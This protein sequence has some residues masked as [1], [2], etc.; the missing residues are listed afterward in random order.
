MQKNSSLIGKHLANYQIERLLG[1]GGMASVYYGVDLQL[2]RPAAI[3]IIDD[4]YSNDPTYADRF[5]HEARAMASWRHPNIPQIYTAGVYR[6]ISFYAM[7][8]IPGEDLGKLLAGLEQNGEFLSY[9]DV[10]LIGRAVAAALDYAHQKG[11]IHRDVKPSNI[12]ISEDDRILL[13]DFGLVLEMDKGTRGEVFGTPQY[14]APEQARNSAL[15]VPQSD[16]YALG[17]MLYEMLTGKLPFED[18]S[19]TSLAL[20]HLTCEPPAPTQ[21]N[22]K[23]SPEIEAV[24][25]KALRKLPEER[26]QT[27]QELM[28]ALEGVLPLPSPVNE[29]HHS[30]YRPPATLAALPAAAE[31]TPSTVHQLNRVDTPSGNPPAIGV[32]TASPQPAAKPQPQA[33]QPRSIRSRVL[34]AILAVCV[35][36]LFCVALLVSGWWVKNKGPLFQPRSGGI[37]LNLGGQPGATATL[38]GKITPPGASS[39]TP[40]LSS[41]TPRAAGTIGPFINQYHVTIAA[42]KDSRLV[43]VNKSVIDLPLRVLR[44]ENKDGQLTGVD[45]GINALRPEQCV[46]ASDKKGREDEQD[47]PTE[48]QCEVVAQRK[49]GGK[50]QEIFW[51][52]SFQVYYRDNLVGTCQ[53]DS[54]CQLDFESPQ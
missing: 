7:E 3:K 5:V 9:E 25:L 37:S 31:K 49:M 21:V 11:A 12:L 34:A 51:R 24:L 32:P 39:L 23:L 40:P 18:P 47:Q 1:R 28:D 38:T 8:Y 41:G 44:L 30:V 19:P 13:T 22:P 2:Q 45:W 46:I 42:Q 27:G 26:Y 20:M 16:L 54:F 53:K 35:L 14:I 48:I 43:L 10:L 33:R 29:T 17:V 4:R 50:D 15:A 36:S 52:N 6:G